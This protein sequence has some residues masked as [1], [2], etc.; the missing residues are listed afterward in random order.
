MPLASNPVRFGAFEL[1]LRA[2]ELR[3]N[4]T[5]VRLQEQPLQL[6]AM[7]LEHPG[8]VVTRDELKRELWSNHTFVDFEHSLNAAVKRL[9]IAL[10]DSADHPRYIETLP[11]HGY[12][13]MVSIEDPPRTEAAPQGLLSG[14]SPPP[15][16]SPSLARWPFFVAAGLVLLLFSVASYVAW[17]SHHRAQAGA[18]V[19]VAVLPL[20]NLSGDPGREFLADGVT[21]EMINQLAHLDPQRLGVIASTSVMPYKNTSKKIRQIGSELGAQYILEG[22]VREDNGRARITVQLI[23]VENQAHVWAESYERDTR[24]ILPIQ[25]DIAR[26]VAQQVRLKLTPSGR[27]GAA[28]E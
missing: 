28:N 12:R 16:P 20:H 26:A 8:A 21:Q 25:T 7:L 2:G 4:G 6:L 19:I 27:D 10:G 3:R 1:D 24:D 13:L 11:R 15:S 22:S 23:A 5:K 14:E 17:R 18:R 9:R